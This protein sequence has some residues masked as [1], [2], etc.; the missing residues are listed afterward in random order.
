MREAQD[1][2]GRPFFFLAENGIDYRLLSPGFRRSSHFT[3]Y[4]SFQFHLGVCR[5]EHPGK[6]ERKSSLAHFET[7]VSTLLSRGIPVLSYFIAGLEGDSKDST[8]DTLS[9][10]STLPTSVGLSMFSNAVPNLAGFE[11]M[12]RFDAIA[13]ER[14]QR[15]VCVSMERNN[16]NR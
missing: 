14:L 12:S 15:L 13:S 9:L 10:L 2:F 7:I 8:V 3:W 5:R 4:D 16:V 1:R 11:N 6:S